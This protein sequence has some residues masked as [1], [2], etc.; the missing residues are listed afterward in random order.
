MYCFPAAGAVMTARLPDA[1]AAGLARCRQIMGGESDPFAAEWDCLPESER[2]FWLNLC[3]LSR[4]DA[5]KRWRDLSGDARCR[6]K[7]GMYRAARRAGVLLALNSDHQGPRSG[8][9][10][11]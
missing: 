6:I 5:R 10:H 3:H 4:F 7:S 11:G 1:A 2:D 8:P 9:L